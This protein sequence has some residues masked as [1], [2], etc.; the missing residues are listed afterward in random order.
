MKRACRALNSLQC[1]NVRGRARGEDC[2]LVGGKVDFQLSRVRAERDTRVPQPV[3]SAAS[4]AAGTVA[5]QLYCVENFRTKLPQLYHRK[6]VS[7]VTVF[8]VCLYQ[9]EVA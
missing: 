4:A 3:Q 7:P 5:L 6:D 2:V 1:E 9:P 8:Q